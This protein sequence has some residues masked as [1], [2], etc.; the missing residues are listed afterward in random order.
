MS[1]QR[2]FTLIEVMIVVAIIAILAAIA[3][4][5]Y[6]DYVTRGRVVEATA[7]LADAR[8]KMEQFFQDN[9]TYPTGGCVIQPTAPGATQ[10]QLQALQNFTLSCAPTPTAT[11][12]KVIA[13]GGGQMAGFTYDINQDNTRTST[14]SG[15]GASAGWTAASPNTCWVLRKGGLC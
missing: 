10:V 12:Y 13:T 9:R 4:P 11:T 6:R 7:G 5:N 14:F 15:S 1:R 8:N 2:G 3:I